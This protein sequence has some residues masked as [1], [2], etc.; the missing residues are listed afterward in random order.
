M[1]STGR[2]GGAGP[3]TTNSGD[4]NRWTAVLLQW[5]NWSLLAKLATI[6]LI[7]LVF[8]AILGGLTIHTQLTQVQ[9][10]SV[11]NRL[12]TF[13]DQIRVVVSALQAERT[14]AAMSSRQAN[15]AAATKVQK[16]TD[17]T[18]K[19]LRS[20]AGDNQQLDQMASMA[21][22]NANDQLGKL[23]TI[24]QQ[25]Q[26]NPDSA[27][28]GYTDAIDQLQMLDSTLGHQAQAGDLAE[29]TMALYDIDASTEEISQQQAIVLLGIARGSVT[30][31]EADLLRA[32]QARQDDKVNDFTAM[33]EPSDVDLFKKTV[34]G[35]DITTRD[36]LVKQAIDNAPTGDQAANSNTGDVSNTSTPLNISAQDYNAVSDS[37]TSKYQKV[38]TALVQ[39]VHDASANLQSNAG[40][41]LTT[42]AA[43]LFSALPFALVA[44]WLIARQLLSSI[45]AL[46]RGARDV[47]AHKLPQ[48]VADI[49]A[50]NEVST[51][52]E[53]IPVETH[54]E[55]GQL[56]RSFDAVHREAR[57]LAV[58]QATLR[59]RYAGVFVNL[60]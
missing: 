19:A 32:S 33:G 12:V 36:Q 48:A 20:T 27:I 10:Y 55:V 42:A 44:V 3:G 37:T 13:N 7:P 1:S 51:E 23:G 52:V 38:A 31:A 17:A 43:V 18:V 4:P 24:R 58:E 56:A 40:S 41:G 45:G 5:R 29:P 59:A 15:A 34:T 26:S 22:M 28:G 8:A 14:Q 25:W 30:P 9:K 21:W 6:A 2:V 49:R 11:A 53:P 50:G 54:E 47:A 35:S 39:K 46:N 16:Q 57:R 60:S